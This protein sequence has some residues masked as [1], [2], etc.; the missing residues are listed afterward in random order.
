MKFN[1]CP[2]SGPGIP[3]DG[4]PSG[5]L[6]VEVETSPATRREAAEAAGPWEI[7]GILRISVKCYFCYRILSNVLDGEGD[8]Q[9]LQQLRLRKRS[10]P[11][12][13]VVVLAPYRCIFS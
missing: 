7:S 12:W 1:G 9:Y 6:R 5:C 10:E 13:Q 2:T 11:C 4:S 3:G 8:V